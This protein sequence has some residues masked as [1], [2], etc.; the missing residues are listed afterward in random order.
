LLKRLCL[1]AVRA[2]AFASV[3][4]AAHSEVPEPFANRSPEQ[5]ARDAFDAEYG[6]LLIDEFARVLR[7]SADEACLA[8]K[9][10]DPMSF[11]TR[12]HEILVRSGTSM[13]EFANRVVDG[14]K[15]DAAFTER[16]GPSG[17]A[18]LILLRGDPDVRKY[19]E[20]AEPGKR[21]R[22]AEHIVETVDRHALLARLGLKRRVSPLAT[23][24]ERL[25]N[26]NP[27]EESTEAAESFRESRNSLALRRWIE[28]EDAAGEAYAEATDIETMKRFGPSQM[29]PTL[30][31]DLA[32]LC[33]VP[34]Q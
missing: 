11:E 23:G 18:E 16:A 5:L 6:R 10:I 4:A 17:K 14:A 1:T 26:A 19:L 15:M 7:A 34:K 12:G 9:S 22:M 13:L 25:L 3:C 20:L 24:D 32:A 33:V 31:S 27:D 21:A 8:A 29:T 2:A 30:P 28:I